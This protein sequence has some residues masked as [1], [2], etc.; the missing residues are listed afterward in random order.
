M[1]QIAKDLKEAQGEAAT[2][3]KLVKAID[4]IQWIQV[5]NSLLASGDQETLGKLKELINN[6]DVPLKQVFIELLVIQ[7]TLSNALTFGLDWGSKLKYKDKAVIGTGNMTPV[8]S[9][10]NQFADTFNA[11]ES[12]RTP[13]GT[14]LNLSNGFDLGIIGDV[15]MHGGKSFLSLGSLL[16]A[17]QTDNETSIIMTPKIITQDGKTSKIF[18][19]TNIPYL[20]SVIQNSSSNSLITSNVEYRDIGMN[21]VITPILGNSDTVTMTIELESTAK[22]DDTTQESLDLGQVNGI[23]TT[24]TT[25]STAVH[26]PNKNFLVLSGMVTDTKT[27]SKSGVPCLGGIPII[28]AAF[29][30]DDKS[31]NKNNIVIFLRPHIINSYRDMINI[32]ENQED[33]FREQTGTPA[34][35]RD[36]DESLETVKSYEND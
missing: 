2:K 32:T 5:T 36:Y 15:L 34:L 19:G 35:E 20:G 23:T 14:D 7:T 29:S 16:Q 26:V 9:G 24:K 13:V 27:R 17:L 12:T 18:S 10:T 28:G 11:I 30:K 33:Y 6:L 25:M 4:S 21:L 3:Y 8:Q 1:K 31:V 22:P